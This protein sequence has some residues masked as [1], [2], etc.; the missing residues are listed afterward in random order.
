MR[1]EEI[2]GST[3]GD[4]RVQRL[5]AN[6]KAANERARELK[7]Q[8]HVAADQLHRAMARAMRPSSRT[9]APIKPSR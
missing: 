7:R 8:V 3:S 6:A 9:L 4:R 5:K 1:L 2:D